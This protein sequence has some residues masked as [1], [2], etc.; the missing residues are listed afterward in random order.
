MAKI[1]ES[2]SKKTK[3]NISQFLEKA[4]ENEMKRVKITEIEVENFGL[5]EFIRP[6]EGTI[7][8]YLSNAIRTT[9]VIKNENDIEVEKIDMEELSD[10]A[11]EF[12]YQCCPLLQ[13]K[14]IRNQYS[15]NEPYDIPS[16]IFG[17]TETLT[18]AGKLVDIF[19]GVKV[20]EKIDETVK[21]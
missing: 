3:L 13:A 4:I 17:T 18:L 8:K 5:I 12:V 20:K 14:E 2:V 6:K 7:L 1:K 15:S 9:K 10:L 16:L 11:S 21:N 19:N